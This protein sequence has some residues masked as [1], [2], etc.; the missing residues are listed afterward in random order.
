MA[1]LK[2]E[3]VQARAESPALVSARQVLE[4]EAQAIQSVIP[5]VGA[6]FETA[7][8]IVLRCKGRIVVTGMGKAGFVAQKLSATFA[9]TGTPSLFLH[10]A[11]ALHGD[12]GRVTPGDVVIALSNSGETDEIAR[13]LPALKR[14]KTPIIALTGKPKSSLGEAATCILN[15]GDIEEACPMGLAPTASAVALLALGDALAMAVLRERPFTQEDYALNHPG[16][17]LGLRL[18]KVGDVM[19]K[20]IK[21]PI[22][23]VDASLTDAFAVM[24][25]CPGRPGATSVVDGL[26]RIVG[27]FTDG[28]LRRLIQRG[29]SDFSAPVSEFMNRSP[30]T[31]KADILAIDAA[32]ILRDMEIDQLPVVDDHNRPV[33]LLDV[34]D[35]LAS[36]I[37]GDE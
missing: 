8:S 2:A 32:V 35:L 30:Q 36:R 6:S 3:S 7:V 18:K 25:S 29:A 5:L 16:G 9:S 22:V 10:P 14:M 11:E 34:Q 26:G 24:T 15:I 1:R 17:R 33:G 27:F 12:L 37:I 31:V 21:N 28:D 20:G 13:M 19:R 4:T 23:P